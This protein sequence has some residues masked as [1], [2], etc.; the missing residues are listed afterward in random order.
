[1]ASPAKWWGLP[2]PPS[3]VTL[4]ERG[5]ASNFSVGSSLTAR[6]QVP[7]PS[8]PKLSD[9]GQVTFPFWPLCARL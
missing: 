1:M 6:V 5:R 4:L 7:A 9:L 2:G 8:L 3:H